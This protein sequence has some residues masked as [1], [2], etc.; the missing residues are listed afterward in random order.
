V[1]KYTTR[2]NTLSRGLLSTATISIALQKPGKRKSIVKTEGERALQKPEKRKH[3]DFKNG[4][5]EH[6]NL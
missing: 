1:R 2:E 6:C 4:K 5:R 3:F